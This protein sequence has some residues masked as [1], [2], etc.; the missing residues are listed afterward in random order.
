MNVSRFQIN[1][2]ATLSLYNISSKNFNHIQWL[3][4]KIEICEICEELVHSVEKKVLSLHL[5][6]FFGENKSKNWK[7]FVPQGQTPLKNWRKK[8]SEWIMSFFIAKKD[9]LRGQNEYG[10]IKFGALFE[11][12]HFKKIMPNVYQ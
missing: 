9:C 3:I 5:L 7:F 6:F 1:V 12:V 8:Q 10:W 2:D 4:H 11:Q